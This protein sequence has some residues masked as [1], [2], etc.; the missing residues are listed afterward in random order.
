MRSGAILLLLATFLYCGRAHGQ[1]Q[2]VTSV[3]TTIS[4]GVYCLAGDLATSQSAGAAITAE[5]DTVLD[6]RG[7]SIEGT[8]GD[9]LTDAIGVFAHDTNNVTIRN[10]TVRGF[11]RGLFVWN[12]DHFRIRDNRLQRNTEYGIQVAG[13]GGSVVGNVVL[14]TGGNGYGNEV[15]GIQTTQ[16]VDIIGNTVSSVAAPAGTNRNAYGI[17]SIGNFGGFIGG[18]RIRG[19]VADGDAFGYGIMLQSEQNATVRGNMITNSG[20]T[21]YVGILCPNFD[22]VVDNIVIGYTIGN[23]GSCRD[24]GGNVF[25]SP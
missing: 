14:D 11:R 12:V 25:P 21:P 18:N 1:C 8:A 3:P 7:H 19:V 16:A 2:V 15:V 4:G 13:L 9:N 24:G 23:A 22:V 6:C 5:Q 10:C 20:A 17:M